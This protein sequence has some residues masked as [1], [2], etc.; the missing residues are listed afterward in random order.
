MDKNPHERHRKRVRDKFLAGGFNDGTPDH[1]ILEMV[2]FYSIPRRDTNE[3]AHTLIDTFGSLSGVFKASADELMK[4][5]GIGE[6]SVALIK[7]I[8]E[9]AR[10]YARDE[11]KKAAYFSSMDEIGTYLLGRYAGIK[12]EMFTLLSLNS[13]GKMLSFD[14]IAR[15]DISQVAV[16]TRKILETVIRT[17]ANA[18]VLAHNHPGGIAI[19]SSEDL[20]ATEAVK[21][22]LAHLD[23]KLLDHLILAEGDY[24][25]LRQSEKFTY[26]FK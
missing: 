18:V 19:P 17:G 9:V 26:L 14:E 25:S 20:S 12:E 7:L 11:K 8:M 15:G 6:N 2:L 16:S 10:A 4:V 1:E 22:V 13:A 24:V 3:L 5:E 23:V 21:N